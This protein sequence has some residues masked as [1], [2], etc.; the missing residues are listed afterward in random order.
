LRI[1]NKIRKDRKLRKLEKIEEKE[2]LKSPKNKISY[3]EE[4]KNADY[5]K[6]LRILNKLFLILNKNLEFEVAFQNFLNEL[7]KN[8]NF[9]MGA[10]LVFDNHEKKLKIIANNKMSFSI[11]SFFLK[12]SFFESLFNSKKGK[13]D[14]IYIIN[15]LDKFSSE[16]NNLFL[17][18]NLKYLVVAPVIKGDT[19]IGYLLL[20]KNNKKYSLGNF[21]ENIINSIRLLLVNIIQLYKVNK[22]LKYSSDYLKLLINSATEYSINSGDREGK[23]KTWNQGAER[24]FGWS[25][26]EVV[27]QIPPSKIFV[28]DD[29]TT[30]FPLIIKKTVHFGEIFEAEVKMKRKNGKEFPSLLTVHPLKDVGNK[31]IGITAIVKDLTEK[32]KMEEKFQKFSKNIKSKNNQTRFLIGKSSE[33]KSVFEQIEKVAKTNLTILMDGESGTGKELLAEII[34]KIS[35]RKYYPFI[36]IDCGAIPETLIESELFGY[37]KGAF[38]G[39]NRRKEGYFELADKGTI[40]LDEIH[41]LPYQVQNKLLR[42]LQ[43]RKIQ[44]LGGKSFKKVNVRI[45]AATNASL[46]DMIKEKKFRSDL[47]FRLNEF[48]ISLP[49]LSERKEDIIFLSNKFLEK[50][51]K[52]WNKDI[53]GFSSEAIKVLLNYSWPGNVRELKNCIRQSALMTDQHIIRPE[54]FPFYTSFINENNIYGKSY[55]SSNKKI[56]KSLKDTEKKAIIDALLT[57]EGN[58]VKVSKVLNINYKTLLAKIKK[59]RLNYKSLL[60]EKQNVFE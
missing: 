3:L 47:Y 15:K 60:V 22:E 29:Q 27:G 28:G 9:E 58:K 46:E 44:K 34:H 56:I 31:I 59:Y 1:I 12:E 23:L 7:L 48:K 39:A 16:V 55:I 4:R 14:I 26:K 17:E 42:F 49:S 20:G 45:L 10:I 6:G 51:K 53:K 52:E 38:T 30:L 43:E 41:N 19:I 54:H 32:K 21:E 57:F 24:M 2:I 35:S 36:A 5:K 8:L 33:M 13:K 18:D 25:A 37:E 40:F 50:A 11:L